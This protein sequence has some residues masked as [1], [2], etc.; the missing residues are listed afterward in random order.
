M[1]LSVRQLS[2]DSDD[3]NRT[4]LLGYQVFALLYR[5]VRIHLQQFFAVNE[6]DGRRKERLQLGITL[7]DKELSA[8]DG[9]IDAADNV[10]Q[11]THRAL[12]ARDDCLPVPLVHIERMKVVELLVG[13]DGVHVRIDTIS[14]LHLVFGQSQSFPFRQRVHNLG[15]SL[16]QVLDGE[17]DR[18]LHAVQVV[19]DAKAFQYEQRCRDAA[20]PQFRAQVLLE[21]LLDQLDSLLR[22]SHVEH[23]PVVCR[24]HNL[25]HTCFPRFLFTFTKLAAK[26]RIK[27]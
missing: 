11:E 26:V 13:A 5:L 20:Q 14:R 12:F 16:S 9:S 21:K 3:E 17:R 22:L 10:L 2:A 4:I 18:T 23:S 15:L 6:M 24:F 25:T 7:A 1:R 27:Y 19:V 8:K